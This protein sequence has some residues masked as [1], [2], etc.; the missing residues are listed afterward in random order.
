VGGRV[1]K[2]EESTIVTFWKVEDSTRVTEDLDT[3]ESTEKNRRRRFVLKFYRVFNLEQCE[4]PQT[5]LEKL[6]KIETHQHDPIEAS[7]RIIAEMP[8]R[9][10]IV[11]GG[12]KAFYCSTTD[13]IT[14]PPPELFTS[15]E[16]EAAVAM[17]EISHAS[18]HPRRLNRK[19][20]S[21]AAPFGSPVYAVEELVAEMSAAFLCTEA[22]ISPAVLDNEAAYVA[23]W[24]KKWRARHFASNQQERI[25]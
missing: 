20:I 21:E 5:V 12:S 7:E 11:R 6:L 24:L 17:H 9:P 15:P 23:G 22:G 25:M 1:C 3:N 4:L 14:L 8:N 10:E 13:Q 18:G 16:D 2:G 19:S